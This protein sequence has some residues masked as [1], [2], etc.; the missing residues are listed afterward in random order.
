MSSRSASTASLGTTLLVLLDRH[1]FAGQRRLVDAQVARADE[2]QVGRHLVPALDEDEVAGHDLGGRQ[3]QLLAGAD[4]GG[5]GGHG[6]TQRLDGGDRP[7][8]LQVAD[9]RVEEDDAEDHRGVDPL[10]EEEG[11]DRRD[12]Q[13]EDERIGELHQEATQGA[14]ALGRRQRVGAELG[15]AVLDREEVEALRAVRLEEVED[16]V[17]GKRVPVLVVE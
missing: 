1:G 15:A 13:D 2:A 6:A 12:Q 9:E 3:P 16:F 17:V 14:G 11:D 4:D 7:G 10:L 8:L 5:L